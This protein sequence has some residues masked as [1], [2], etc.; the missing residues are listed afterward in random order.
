MF[1]DVFR[2]RTVLVTGHTGFK[3]SW[4]TAWLLRLGARVVGVSNGVPT[5]PAN[6]EVLGLASRITDYRCDIRDAE[7]LTEIICKEQPAFV[8]HLAA[9]A[10]V[11]RSYAFPL[12]TF[13]TNVI[14][15]ANVLE[16]I[17]SSLN[18]CV[19]IIVTSD[20]CYENIESLWGYKESDT[21]GGKDIYS[22]SKAAAEL[23]TRSLTLSVLRDSDIRVATV[24]AGNVLG[25]GDWAESRVVPDCV[26]AWSQGQTVNLRNVASTRPWQHVLEPLSGYMNLACELSADRKLHG[27]AFNF[28][29]PVENCVPVGKLVEDLWV[30]WRGADDSRGITVTQAPSFAEAGLL[31]LNCEKAWHVL[32]WRS[33]LA[34]EDMVRFIADWYRSFVEGNHDMFSLTIGQISEYQDRA[35]VA[36]RPWCNS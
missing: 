27:Q 30:R 25:G 13:T 17:R 2:G 4:L 12:D 21:L 20:K 10:I 22:A 8:F 36:G 34:Y 35:Q 23:V 15:T 5:T 3:G 11:S 6:Y 33:T 7:G 19:A 24:R 29:P 18:S 31:T 26:R 9:Q 32:R 28:G 1:S 16:A 14:G